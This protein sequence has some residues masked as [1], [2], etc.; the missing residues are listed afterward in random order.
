MSRHQLVLSYNMRLKNR[1]REPR[2][3]EGKWSTCT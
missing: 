3:D 1:Y 2:N